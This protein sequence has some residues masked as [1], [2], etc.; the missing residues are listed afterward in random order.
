MT[1]RILLVDDQPRNLLALAALLEPEGYELLQAAHGRVALDVLARGGVDLVLLDLMM[2]D[3]DG[4]EV[5][6]LLRATEAG[7]HVPVVL[8]TAHADREHRLRALRAGADDFLEKPIDAP[9]LLARVRALL[10]LKEALDT[11]KRR[12]AALHEAQRENRELSALLVRDLTAPLG[13]V[14]GAIEAVRGGLL[15]T[16]FNLVG[17][18]SDARAATARMQNL[19][20][21]LLTLS[22]LESPGLNLRREVLVV[23][24]I[25]REV[26][27]SYESRAEARNV[28]LL[29][30]PTASVAMK[31]DKALL[32]R[33]LENLLDNALRYTP[34]KGRIGVDLAVRDG[35]EITVSNDGAP[36]RPED[37]A[38]IFEKFTRGCEEPMH[39]GH[40]GLGLYFCRRALEAH[41]G[42]IRLVETT[43]WPTSFLLRLP[44]AFKDTVVPDVSQGGASRTPA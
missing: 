16:Q 31:A 15:P 27:A 37:R 44:N 28:T 24:K 35:I 14:S 36:I 34:S 39:E 40:S 23:A 22:R 43:N 12:N 2:P 4:V 3:L 8:V 7:A 21:D 29:R 10:G 26:L 5:L 11:L 17:P 20:R 32:R 1:K 6:Q 9:V 19:V 33:V 25:L 13:V 42:T 30:P 18:I 38:R 41:G